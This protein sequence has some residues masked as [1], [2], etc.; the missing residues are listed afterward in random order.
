[1]VECIGLGFLAAFIGARCEI[2]KLGALILSP[3]NFGPAG[4]FSFHFS[5][6]GPFYAL[7]LIGAL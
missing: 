2:F 1:M 6:F 3:A 4:G 5:F 7:G